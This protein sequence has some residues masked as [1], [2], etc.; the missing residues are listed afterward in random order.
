MKVSFLIFIA[1]LLLQVN[2]SAQSLIGKY[3]QT[4]LVAPDAYRDSRND[5][6]IVQDLKSTKMVWV[7]NLIPKQKFYAILNTKMDGKLIYAVPKQNVGG[8]QISIGCITYEEGEIS[9]SLNNK[10]NCFGISQSDYDKP[11]TVSKKGVEAGGVK[12]NS[13]GSIKGAGV[14]INKDKITVNSKAAMEGIQY[15]G[16]KQGVKSA[17]TD[18]DDDD[19]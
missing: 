14:D 3:D 17:K 11:V 19:K 18:D 5:L 2:A 8:Y 12:V 7:T 10:M 6:T 15:V 4:A 1:S 16:H 13:D 9:I